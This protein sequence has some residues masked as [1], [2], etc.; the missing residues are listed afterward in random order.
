MVS[1][2]QA[3]V[4]APRIA[5]ILFAL[6]LSLFALD[7]FTDTESVWEGIIG[8]L[9]HLTPTWLVLAFLAMAWRWPKVG[10]VVYAALGCFYIVMAWGRFPIATYLIIAGPAF[11]IGALFL[12]SAKFVCNRR[13]PPRFA[14][15]S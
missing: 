15:P 7:A 5:T 8:F 1:L 10:A 9:I 14:D 6:F 11:V 13:A 12:A 2:P 4:W 3:L